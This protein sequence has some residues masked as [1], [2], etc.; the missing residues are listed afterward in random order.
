MNNQVAT[1]GLNLKLLNSLILLM[2]FLS[3]PMWA[4]SKSA[5][6]NLRS[7]VEEA[8]NNLESVQNKCS[9]KQLRDDLERKRDHC[10]ISYCPG[11][12][13]CLDWDRYCTD[14]ELGTGEL[15]ECEALPTPQIY[16]CYKKRTAE[17]CGQAEKVC[18]EQ[19]SCAQ[20]YCENDPTVKEAEEKLLKCQSE[21]EAAM[22]ELKAAIEAYERACPN[23]RVVD[24]FTH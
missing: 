9:L 19:W 21:N 22:A 15:P 10:A 11:Y 20:P 16:E 12:Q 18:M 8:R 17:V 23:R 13:S 7:A 1:L 3:F 5:C 4:R 6:D 14:L 2:V 24:I